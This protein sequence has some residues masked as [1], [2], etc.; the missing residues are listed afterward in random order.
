V[1]HKDV[2]TGGGTCCGVQEERRVGGGIIKIHCIPV[3][4]CQRIGKRIFLK[5]A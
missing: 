1:K 5:E 3:R 2:K 4:K